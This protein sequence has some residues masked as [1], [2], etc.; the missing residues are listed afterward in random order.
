MV[1]FFDGHFCLPWFPK[2]LCIRQITISWLTK[3]LGD[4]NRRVWHIRSEQFVGDWDGLIDGGI[5]WRVE[6]RP[7]RR[8]LTN[9]IQIGKPGAQLGQTLRILGTGRNQTLRH[10]FSG[11]ISEIQLKVKFNLSTQVWVAVFCKGNQLISTI[12]RVFF[13]FIDRCRCDFAKGQRRKHKKTR[14]RCKNWRRRRRLPV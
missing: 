9:L 3:T 8:A 13:E 7:R 14:D 12:V 1:V 2:I 10:G 6:N 4:Q 5:H 11:I